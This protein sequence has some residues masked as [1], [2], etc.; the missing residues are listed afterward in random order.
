MWFAIGFCGA[1]IVGSYFYDVLSWALAVVLLLLG[2]ALIISTRWI[3]AIRILAVLT[4]SFSIGIFW[5]LIYD[6]YYLRNARVIDGEIRQ[7]V[8]ELSDYSYPTSRGSAATGWLQL[9]GK[10]YQTLIYFDSETRL[11]P[12]DWVSGEFYLSFT[13][14]S[15]DASYRRSEGIFLIA[16]QRGDLTAELAEE[17][18]IYGYP[19][20]WRMQ[21][22]ERIEQLFPEDAAA[23]AKALLLG[24]RSG[25]SYETSTAFKVSGISHIIAVSGLHVSILF[26]LIYLLC[27]RK[28]LPVFLV[29]FP[30]LILFAAVTGFTPSVT[31][32]CIM[33]ALVL[34][35]MLTDREYDPP[36]ALSFAAFT[37]L[38]INPMVVV[39]I[40]F[41][42]T[43]GCMV[44]IFLFTPKIQNW[45]LEVSLLKKIKGKGLPARLRSWFV[46]SVS[47]SMGASA[48]TVP[49]VAYH[50]GTISL[51]SL[52]TNLLVV[53]LI[54]YIFYGIILACVISAGSL[55]IGKLIAWLVVLPIR[56]VIGASTKLSQIPLA[57]V[58]TESIYIV[59]WLV[60]VY[61]LLGIFLLMKKKPVWMF[62]ALCTI[63]LCAALC[64][65]W[66]EP[67][68]NTCRVTMLDVGQGQC[69][70]L[71][72]E[73]KSFLVDCGGE[74]DSECAD[75]AAETLLSQG[76]RR[77]DGLI[78]THYDRDH[79]GGVPYLLT[80]V[81]ADHIYLP[82]IVDP[83]GISDQIRHS[84]DSDTCISVMEDLS[85][86]YGNTALTIFGPENYNLENES[87]LCILFQAE[88]C[89]IMITG[90]RSNFGESLLLSRVELP[91]LDLLI[92]GH[93]GSAKSTGGRL[94]A[95]TRPQYVFISVGEN[96][97]GHPASELLQRLQQF[98]CCVYRTD[99]NGTIVFR[100]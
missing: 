37:M 64:A 91:K 87:S 29:G 62:G 18:P 32:A 55:F 30:A 7:C 21:I 82:N 41:Q 9:E 33:Q 79:A 16:G 54:S 88:N 74:W 84:A 36:T 68:T 49:L 95:Q 25:I 40:S 93:H 27:G 20:V 15:E 69:I 71:Q 72:S 31:R 12:G 63:S 24:D 89:D 10:P 77:L 2:F 78:V 97:Y 45:L 43:V 96:R 67:W 86:T 61:L 85:L 42:L 75:L 53:W 6:N 100:G 73:G 22:S 14:K 47:V 99:Q 8:I 92:A 56:I 80:R 34:L 66:M 38:V 13:A 65:S 48:M 4:L 94:L 26:S 11:S 23:F 44:G 17:T 46:T 81:S 57:A 1:S 83:Y 70:L 51:I 50:F 60:G 35:A 3:R 58:Y 28:R 52:L 59:V 76:I 19:A 5:F 90:D 98:G 39:S